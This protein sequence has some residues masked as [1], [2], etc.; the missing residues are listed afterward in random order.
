MMDDAK[1]EERAI[2]FFNNYGWAIVVAIVIIIILKLLGVDI[3]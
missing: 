1:K 3:L 2:D